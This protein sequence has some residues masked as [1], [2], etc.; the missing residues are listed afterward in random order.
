MQAFFNHLAVERGLA[1][2]SIDAYRRAL[3]K[4]SEHLTQHDRYPEEA[5]TADLA[6]FL[7][8][9]AAAGE[10][11]STIAQRQAA[12]V[13]FYRW[14]HD[15][16][17]IAED[18]TANLDRPKTERQPPAI[19]TRTELKRLASADVPPRDKAII[20]LLGHGLTVTE[21]VDLDL[22]HLQL[23]YGYVQVRAGVHERIVP[24]SPEAIA[25]V[26][27]YLKQVRPHLRPRVY[28][29]ALL[30]NYAGRRLSRQGAWKGV[31]EAARKAR[32]GQKVTPRSLRQSYA[33][34]LLDQGADVRTIQE[35]LGHK[36][37][38]TTVSFARSVRALKEKE[39]A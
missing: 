2:N 31:K 10:S 36:D 7:A 11:S 26:D 20:A 22:S 37:A 24:L 15:R 3:A 17:V 29:K 18:P 28:E 8:A 33:A 25:A 12:L 35:M 21:L 16:Q 34:H 38:S 32:L 13:A 14:L 39:A 1:R 30:L 19:L 5:T 4:L 6:E 23:G 9:L 27:F